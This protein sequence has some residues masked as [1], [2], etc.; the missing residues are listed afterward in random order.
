MDTI[1]HIIL[2][3]IQSFNETLTVPIDVSKGLDTVLFGQGGVLESIDFVSLLLD[4]E[5]A[6]SEELQVEVSLM[7][8]KAL[9]EKR[10]PFRTVG[11][12]ADY[13]RTIIGR[14]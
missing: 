11:V 5:E 8:E 13:V 1:A 9:S 2:R 3:Q 6:L 7:N 4:I 10:S 12:L 14:S